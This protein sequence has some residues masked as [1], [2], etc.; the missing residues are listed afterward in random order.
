MFRNI[1][2]V[3][4]LIL[5]SDLYSK[6]DCQKV[7]SLIHSNNRFD[8]LYQ[9]GKGA[10]PCL[11]D[12]IDIEKRTSVG[13]IDPLSSNIPSFV[14][15]NYY[16]IEA[17]F[18]IEYILGKDSLQ[19]TINNLRNRKFGNPNLF[20][21]GVIVKKEDEKK[22]FE[23]LKYEDMLAIKSIYAK[24]WEINR[25]KAIAV[26]REEWNRN[27]RPLNGSIYKWI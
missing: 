21:Y 9:M 2:L 6:G 16:G 24:W 27:N 18:I 10:I 22:G 3:F 13:F 17:A 19:I 11:I 1:F 4:I 25:N 12:F 14:L 15:N 5:S 7:K 8:T 26:L 23:P 20:A